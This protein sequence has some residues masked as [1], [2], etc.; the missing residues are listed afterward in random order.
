MALA[1]VKLEKVPEP[2]LIVLTGAAGVLVK[3]A[4]P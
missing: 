4:A 2:V 3:G 1:L